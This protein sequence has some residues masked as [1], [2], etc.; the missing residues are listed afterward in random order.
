[1][2]DK[3]TGEKI[4][5]DLTLS[6]TLQTDPNSSSS[7]RRNKKFGKDILSAAQVK[8]DLESSIKNFSCYGG[9]VDNE[10]HYPHKGEVLGELTVTDLEV[11]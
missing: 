4:D 9:S 11:R 2:Y 10:C 7:T 1:L 8:E 5:P 3:I 6:F